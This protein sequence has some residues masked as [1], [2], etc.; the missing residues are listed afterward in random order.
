LSETVQHVLVSLIT[1]LLFFVL[2]CLTEHD[3]D[4]DELDHEQK[5]GQ[6]Q[7]KEGNEETC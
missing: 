2:M 4:R 5:N 3:S 1:L 7:E 6:E